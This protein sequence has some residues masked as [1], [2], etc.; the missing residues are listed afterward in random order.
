MA[1]AD[2]SMT[3]EEMAAF[4]E[5]GHTIVVAT[6]GRD[7]VP[8]LA[9]MWYVMEAGMVVFRSFTK[10][11]KILNLQRDSRVTVLLET[12]EKYEELKGVMIRGKARLVDD[13]AYTLGI[14]GRLAGK[15]AMVGDAPVVLE[16]EALE[17]AFGRFAPK[18][19]SV[20]VE[21]ERVASWDHTK[22][23]GRY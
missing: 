14:Y 10:S 12:G 21:P 8:H 11:Q 2:I 22:L 13:P 20:M 18:N 9:P 19:T 5:G 15:Y 7:G 16:G 6:V 17:A 4:L 3:P 1:R 23:G